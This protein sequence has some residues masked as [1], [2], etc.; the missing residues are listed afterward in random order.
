MSS[1]SKRVRD[2][3]KNCKDKMDSSGG[4]LGLEETLDLIES[5]RSCK[6]KFEESVD[7]SV[8]LGVD[9][10]RT[11]FSIKTSVILPHG[12]GKKIKAL[13]FA[14]GDDVQIAKNMGVSYV[15]LEELIDKIVAGDL[16]PGQDFTT[17]VATLDSMPT[18]SKSKAV[19]I[20]GVAG[21]MPNAKVGTVAKDLEPILKEV[22]AG[23]MDIKGDRAAFIRTS[24]GRI[25]FERNQIKENLF[26]VYNAIKAAKPANLKSNLFDSISVSSSMMGISL[27]IKMADFYANA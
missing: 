8:H 2:F 4:Y 11:E 5:Y 15:G 27:R 18:L 1:K 10:K 16:V 20:L 19:R 6:A 25:N 23:R 24:I 12:N 7:V 14:S 13:V 3:V 26:A 9:P 21:M 22:L 17:C